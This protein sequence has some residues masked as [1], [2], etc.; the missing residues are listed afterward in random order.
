[1]WKIR[2][3]IP[4]LVVEGSAGIDALTNPALGLNCVNNINFVRNTPF[5]QIF[6]D[7]ARVILIPSLFNESFCRVAAEAMASGVPIIASNRG[8]IPETVQDAGILLDIPSKYTPNSKIVPSPEELQRWIEAILRF[9]DD[10]AFCQ[11][12][13]DLGKRRAY[14]LGDNYF[15][16]DRYDQQFRELIR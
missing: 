16:I 3:D 11:K 6:Y 2:P 15:I 7:I 14:S 1:M 10:E 13:V 9:W 8:A 4:I 12:Y 5:P